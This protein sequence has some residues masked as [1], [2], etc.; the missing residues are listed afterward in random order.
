MN[1]T[2]LSVLSYPPTYYEQIPK[3]QTLLLHLEGKG[4]SK[5]TLTAIAKALKALAIRAD[6]D[7]PQTVE[8]AIARYQKQDKQPAS[9][10]YK[11]KLCDA[12]QHYCKL[13]KIE[14]EKPIYTPEETGIQ[15]PTN[16]KIQM[17][18]ASAKGTLSLKIQISAETGLRPI[19]IHGNKGLRARNIHTDQKTITALSTK[20]CN[21]RPPMLM[22]S[23]LTAR[24][25]T[26]IT[27]NN[28]Q[29]DE[30]LFKGDERRYGE[31]Y[32]RFRNKLAN[33]LNDQ[34]I[35]T[36]RL[37]DLRHAYVTKQL[38]RTQNAET[39]RIII[40]HKKLNTT[41][42]YLH[43]LANENGEWEVEGT[44]DKER[45]KQL[46]EADFTYILTIPDGTM[47][48]RKRK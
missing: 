15:P 19:E 40:G 28:I 29:P 45:A 35:R 7:N 2:Q 24:L 38:R 16:E 41:Q 17:L 5:N 37:Y 23:E 26:Y 48:F 11:C 4:R 14:W 13:Y 8:L 25:Q 32:R 12:Y 44:T 34:T 22:T 46:L 43:L 31:H 30:L 39:V 47:M 3:I 20:R 10:N 1:P 18:I 9:N 36:I 21:A 27:T 33:K 42:K 6:L